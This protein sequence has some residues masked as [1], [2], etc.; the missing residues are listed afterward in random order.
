MQNI[1][2]NKAFDLNN[3][4]IN[5][6]NYLNE[7][8]NAENN[9]RRILVVPTA[10]YARHLRQS[11]IR[12]YYKKHNAPCSTV[13]IINFDNFIKLLYE[14]IDTTAE[15]II[16][17]ESY[18]FLLFERA[19][20]QSNSKYFKQ[21]NGNVK[22][23]VAKKVDSLISGLKKKGISPEQIQKDLTT[24]DLS[25]G[26]INNLNKYR[27]I[28]EIYNNYQKLLGENLLDEVDILKFIINSVETSDSSLDIFDPLD[29]KI[30]SDN[31]LDKYLGDIEEIVFY[32]F[33]DFT[34]PELRL[35][36]L[37]SQSNNT[38]IAL[39]LENI[40]TESYDANTNLSTRLLQ[41][42]F[43]RYAQSDLFE[44]D[45]LN[46]HLK[47]NLFQK[48]KSKHLVDTSAIPFYLHPT[49]N[50]ENE[51][52][53]VS[54]FVSYLIRVENIKPQDIAVVHREAGTNTKYFRDSFARYR[55]PLNI[56]DRQDL[57][58]STIVTTL[59]NIY[60]TV[61]YGYKLK[62]LE[63]V[64]ASYYMQNLDIDFSIIRKYANRLKIS[65]GNDRGK[66]EGW[67]K[68]FESYLSFLN[69]K[70][71][72]DTFFVDDLEKMSYANEV[73]EIKKSIAALSQIQDLF[74]NLPKK[75]TIADFVNKLLETTELVNFENRILE[76]NKKIQSSKFETKHLKESIQDSIEKDG[77]A[78]NAL[79]ILLNE[80]SSINYDNTEFYDTLEL[81]DM[82]RILCSGTKY[83]I[84]EKEQY[85]VTL[86]SIEQTRGLPYKYVIMCSACEGKFPLAF[87]TNKLLGKD[88]PE[89]SKQHIRE[90]RNLL[91]SLLTGNLSDGFSKGRKVVIS[92][93]AKDENNEFSR[94]H[95]I[96]ELLNAIPID[97]ETSIL[98]TKY[99][100]FADHV[101]K[102]GKDSKYHYVAKEEVYID[103]ENDLD[104]AKRFS[105]PFAPTQFERYTDCP[106]RFMLTSVL[107][108]PDNQSEDLMLTP[109]E[110]GSLL[111]KILYKFYDNLKTL[112]IG[113]EN[114]AQKKDGQMLKGIRLLR[115]KETFYSEL[116]NTI[117]NEEIEKYTYDHPL[118]MVEHGKIFGTGE[119]DGMLD[120]WLSNEIKLYETY[121]DRFS[122][123]F[124]LPFGEPNN[125]PVALNESVYIRG[126]IDRIEIDKHHNGFVVADYKTKAKNQNNDSI[127]SF[128]RFQMPLY[129]YAIS[130]IFEG[131]LD[132]KLQHLF[133]VYYS[134][135]PEDQWTK[136]NLYSQET[137]KAY[138]NSR[139]NHR[140]T[141]TQEELIE[142]IDG[143]I[144]EAVN[145]ANL[146]R[147]G[148]YPITPN[149]KHSYCSNCSYKQVCRISKFKYIEKED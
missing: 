35:L 124:E 146:I 61:L 87:K 6:R 71:Q 105:K 143:Y 132:S 59:I 130:I 141:K 62:N 14:R 4:F 47:S 103:F 79:L 123:F 46:K 149:I 63:K 65:G 90:E 5:F 81:L 15:K 95:F 137:Y 34:I 22:L 13:N 139:A 16:I 102:F 106:F 116:L 26:E 28:Y 72:D 144:H 60:E 134:L 41:L 135:T 84:R 58:T 56:T 125:T 100:D 17:S 145:I 10:K 93:A 31:R 91:Y 88:L 140:E 119:G 127:E 99:Y 86:T 97:D 85:G 21:H 118:F 54:K 11:Y 108:I 25:G 111:H 101:P 78:Y 129:S 29:F 121:Q 3:I 51:I 30:K 12:N 147:K 66:I 89:S 57:Q 112:G 64:F 37:F 115:A 128:T 136:Y 19:I 36:S 92:Y 80:L 117:A 40:E 27:D 69:Q 77:K 107:M 114:V 122:V 70:I 42:G 48:H 148:C 75:M 68:R 39:Y 138:F 113:I 32:G 98:L 43:I 120:L 8:V 126:K 49:E 23:S 109:L 67:F 7:W 9:D 45:P 55:I 2:H 18:R 38:Q 33:S 83:Q 74:P 20:K 50:S 1:F 44:E 110:K 96:D 133:G 142:R 52:E 94:T 104:Y 76:D 82:F 24:P 131:L 53:D 73:E